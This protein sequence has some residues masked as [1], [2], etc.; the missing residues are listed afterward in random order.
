M[1][2]FSYAPTTNAHLV[3]WVRHKELRTTADYVPRQPHVIHSGK[4]DI[5]AGGGKG[6]VYDT[7]IN[8]GAMYDNWRTCWTP[9]N[10]GGIRVCPIRPDGPPSGGFMDPKFNSSPKLPENQLLPVAST[11]RKPYFNPVL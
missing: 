7:L 1:N 11:F 5:M 6:S 8:G 9:E 3:D 10:R 2:G 4:D